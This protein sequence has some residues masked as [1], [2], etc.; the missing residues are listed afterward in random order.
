L[1]TKI[2]TL[3]SRENN[4]FLGSHNFEDII[5][6]VAGCVEIADQTYAAN[7]KLNSYLKLPE[8]VVL[9]AR[10]LYHF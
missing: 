4:D 6:V 2:E 8:R 9:T 1:A 5:T 10:K 3:K 7:D